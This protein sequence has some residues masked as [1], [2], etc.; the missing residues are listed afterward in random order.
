MQKVTSETRKTYFDEH[1]KKSPTL[2]SH[3]RDLGKAG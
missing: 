1:D 2:H 3:F